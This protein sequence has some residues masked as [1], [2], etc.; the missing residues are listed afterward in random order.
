MTRLFI[1][2]FQLVPTCERTFGGIISWAWT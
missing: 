1:A 2:R